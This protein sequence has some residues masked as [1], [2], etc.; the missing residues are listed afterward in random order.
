MR[1]TD[2]ASAYGTL[3]GLQSA[4]SRLTSLQG[5]LSSGRQITAPSDNPAGTVRAL[6]L[7]GEAKRYSQYDASASDAI[8]WLSTAD[9]AYTRAVALVQDVRTLVVQG[10]NTGVQSAG[11]SA[12]L[13]D[14]VDAIRTSLIKVANTTYNGRPV[15]GGTTSG[16]AAYDSSGNYVG[17]TGTVSRTVGEKVSV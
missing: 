8:G 12:A 7:R 4:A 9:A 16:A 15:F 10:L 13:A 11:A 14:Q 3:A 1:V 2:R 5:Q 6:Q 17:D